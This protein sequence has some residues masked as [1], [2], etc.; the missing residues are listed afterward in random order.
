MQF[1]VEYIIAC[2]MMGA[3]IGMDVALVTALYSK[4]LTN[5]KLVKKR[6]L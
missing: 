3:A 1:A 6:L 2:L 5:V 4:K